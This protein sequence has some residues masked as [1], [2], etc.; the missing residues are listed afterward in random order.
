MTSSA[1]LDITGAVVDLLSQEPAIADAVYRARD[2]SVPE[3]IAT[4]L[5]VQMIGAVP[6]LGALKGAPVDW[7]T[8]ISVECYA[9]GTTGAPD[10]LVDP[11]LVAVYSRLA[12][13][14]TL[15]GLVD[16]IGEPVLEAEYSSEGKKTGWVC[17]T[18]T[19]QHRTG[20]STLSNQ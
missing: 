11:L 3:G 2:K 20:N 7:S 5:S 15:G 6:A 16:D 10:Q 8:R 19:V 18:Y 12:Q 17:M 1:F 13:H 14:T 4:A 9:R